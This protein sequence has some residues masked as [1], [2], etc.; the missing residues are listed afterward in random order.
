MLGHLAPE[1]KPYQHHLFNLEL[2]K[3]GPQ[4][5][6]EGME[7]LGAETFIGV[8]VPQQIVGQRGPARKISQHR[9]PDALVKADS[10]DQHNWSRAWSL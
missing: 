7:S 6:Y 1:G 4:L 3:Q 9:A 10:M 2:F 5:V 8:A